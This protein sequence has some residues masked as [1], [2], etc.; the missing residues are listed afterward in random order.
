MKDIIKICFYFLILLLLS[1]NTSHYTKI[2][3]SKRKINLDT[4]KV[5]DTIYKSIIIRNVGDYNLLIKKMESSCGCTISKIKDSIV[6]PGKYTLARIRIIVPNEEGEFERS[7]VLRS[8][9][10]E[11]FSIIDINGFVLN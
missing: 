3:I 2:E 5:N 10:K 11:I 8:N 6:E 7:I 9:A 4:I 1:C